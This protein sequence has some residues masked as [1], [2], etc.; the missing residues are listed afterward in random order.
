MKLR[1]S[2]VVLG[3]SP[4]GGVYF[5]GFTEPVNFTD[6]FETP[7]LETLTGRA[8]DA[9]HSVDFLQLSPV[10]ESLPPLQTLSTLVASRAAAGRNVPPRTTAILEELAIERTR[11]AERADN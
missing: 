1:S 5:A 2:E 9:G 8:I 11:G 3:P 7:A 4:D 10:V 6:A